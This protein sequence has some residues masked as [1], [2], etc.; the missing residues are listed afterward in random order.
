LQQRTDELAR[1]NRDLE[2]FAATVAHDLRT[3]LTSI[4]GCA[5]LLE[6]R[7]PDHADAESRELLGFIQESTRRMG[8]MIESM[9]HYARAGARPLHCKRCDL[10]AVFNHVL[11][12][13]RS[14]L[15][16]DRAQVT[17]EPLPTVP[18][19][20]RLL[21]QVFQNLIE[22]AVKYRGK[23]APKVRITATRAARE[24]IVSIRDNGAGIAPGD[25]ARIFQLFE[26]AS[27][28]S[29]RQPG[30]GVGLATC[31]RIIERHGGRIWVES[32]LGAG[33]T[34]HLALPDAPPTS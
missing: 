1:S 19:D 7:L 27:Q 20:E 9:L 33:S 31:K 22:N 2:Q 8:E 32:Q 13:L 25:T 4:S 10:N 28:D 30:S 17:A 16:N 5:K 23:E 15:D 34:F 12:D 29:S 26:R 11:A 18:A 21:A 24:W 6:P 3:P 14:A